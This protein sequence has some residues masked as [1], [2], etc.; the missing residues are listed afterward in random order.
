METASQDRI[1]DFG[2]MGMWWEITKSTADTGGELFEAINVL[3]PGFAGPP[4]HIHPSAE[5]S[6]AVVS[7][8]LDVCVGGEWRKLTAGESVTVPAGT[9]HTLKNESGAEVKLVNVHKPALEF[10]RFFRRLHALACS[11]R[12][13]FPP[14]GLRSAI[15]LSML[16]SEHPQEII[17]VKPPRWLMKALARVGRILGY[18]LPPEGAVG[19]G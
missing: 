14:K 11:G 13:R 2:P 4:L 9:P 16:F 10:E 18:K 8:T 3:A 12:V 7:G 5:E 19:Q 17:S 15:L 6:Y 1:L